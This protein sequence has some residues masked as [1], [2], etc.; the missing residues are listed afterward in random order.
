MHPEKTDNEIIEVWLENEGSRFP[1][2]RVKTGLQSPLRFLK[3]KGTRADLLETAQTMW[4][5]Y[6]KAEGRYAHCMSVASIAIKNACRD[7]R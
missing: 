6:S 3:F 1:G 2:S 4:E 5:K 7:V